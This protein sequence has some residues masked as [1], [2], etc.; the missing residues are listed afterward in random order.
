MLMELF[1]DEISQESWLVL[2]CYIS[3]HHRSQTDSLSDLMTDWL[4]D[5][6]S[7]S[8]ELSCLRLADNW[9]CISDSQ[10]EEDQASFPRQTLLSWPVLVNYSAHHSALSWLWCN[11]LMLP[12]HSLTDHGLRTFHGRFIIKIVWFHA[13]YN[14]YESNYKL[15]TFFPSAPIWCLIMTRLVFLNLSS[16][17]LDI[18]LSTLHIQ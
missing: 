8:A 14:K 17:S 6:L 1:A 18:A 9:S 12:P 15:L 16:A 3:P 13:F 2:F 4:T 7:V 10:T 5:C 11:H